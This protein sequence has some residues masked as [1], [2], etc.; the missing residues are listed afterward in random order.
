MA[1]MPVLRAAG[2]SECVCNSG[3]LIPSARVQGDSSTNAMSTLPIAGDRRPFSGYFG[4]ATPA[5]GLSITNPAMNPDQ[6]LVTLQYP[7]LGY[8]PGYATQSRR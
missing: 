6:N 2:C 8:L 3:R 5:W 7:V 1:K 4:A